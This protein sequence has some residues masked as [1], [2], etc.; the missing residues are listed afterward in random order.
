M[1]GAV[2]PSH[3]SFL[4]ST[5]TRPALVQIKSPGRL[6]QLSLPTYGQCVAVEYATI[7]PGEIPRRDKLSG[8]AAIF[9]RSAR[10]EA[11]FHGPSARNAEGGQGGDGR[12]DAARCRAKS[13]GRPRSLGIG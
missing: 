9:C 10:K 13:D 1:A 12:L 3:V 2:T 7:S 11:A 5:G 8:R 6:S 4:T